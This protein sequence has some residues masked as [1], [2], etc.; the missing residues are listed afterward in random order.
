MQFNR[1]N[2]GNT[3]LSSQRVKIVRKRTEFIRVD[4]RKSCF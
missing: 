2:C 1:N 4:A 3:T